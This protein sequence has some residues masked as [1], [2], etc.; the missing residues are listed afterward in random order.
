MAKNTTDYWLRLS[1][2]I[3]LSL[4][5]LEAS[6]KNRPAEIKELKELIRKEEQ[7]VED[8]IAAATTDEEHEDIKWKRIL[9]SRKR[10]YI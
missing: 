6:R 9:I 7:L 8:L 1:S 2:Y 3:D 4:S 5:N 10:W